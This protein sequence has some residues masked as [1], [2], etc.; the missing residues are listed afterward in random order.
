VVDSTK[1]ATALKDPVAAAKFFTS[2]TDVASD[3]NTGFATRMKTF[4][5][6]AIGSAGTIA[7]KTTSLQSQ[8]TSNEKSQDRLS[9]RLTT[10]EANMRKQYT[11]LDTKMASL[12]ALN[13]Y[14]T[15][16]IAQWNKS[17]S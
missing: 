12:T 10:V 11:A 13:T 15:Q 3:G 9:D 7:A 4:L 6:G 16:Q 14:I 1:L 8:K 5:S 17:T 2:A